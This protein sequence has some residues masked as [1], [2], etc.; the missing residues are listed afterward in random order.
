[1]YDL[2]RTMTRVKQMPR[3][4]FKAAKKQ[5]LACIEQGLVSHEVRRQIDDKNYL[6]SGNA[7]LTDIKQIISRCSG[8]Q[9]IS[10]PHHL[11]EDIEVHIVK[12]TFGYRRWYIK[13]YF[14]EPNVVFIGV[15][16][17]D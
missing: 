12:T 13:W 1:M 11:N 14:L 7:S 17:R 5:V 4:G 2:C 6:F 10:S 8:T 15:H 3:I 16:V 9:Y